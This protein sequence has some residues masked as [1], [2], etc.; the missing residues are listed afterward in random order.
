VSFELL[1]NPD[2]NCTHSVRFL[3]EM[4]LICDTAPHARSFRLNAR[5]TYDRQSI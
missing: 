3:R 4:G 2:K 1:I 5:A